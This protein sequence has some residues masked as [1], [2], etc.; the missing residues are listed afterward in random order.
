M[1]RTKDTVTF[2]QTKSIVDQETGEV[3]AQENVTK[4]KRAAEPNYVKVY[5]DCLLTFK[6]LSKSLNPILLE[7]LRH[8][9]YADQNEENGGQI[10]YVNA[11]MKRNI[12]QKLN[13]K[14]DRLNQSLTQ[15]VKS[16]IFKRLAPSTYQ[17][18]PNLF[19]KGEWGDIKAIRAT[20]DF[21]TGEINAEL[22]QEETTAAKEQAAT[23]QED[24]DQLQLFG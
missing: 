9:S 22:S 7:F 2:V 11:Q 14:M 18:N 24:E 23:S 5:I 3:L 4:I 1:A 17:V 6:E 21:N 8:M 20:F 10:I 19:G 16:N 12:A 13:L 15:F